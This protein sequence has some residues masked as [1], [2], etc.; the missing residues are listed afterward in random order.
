MKYFIPPILCVLF[1][2]CTFNSQDNQSKINHKLVQATIYQ[3][4]AA[5]KDALVYQAYNLAKRQ[6]DINI[7]NA[8][9][10]KPLAIISDI[11]E[12]LVDNSL[13]Y[14]DFISH[15]LD[16]PNEDWRKWQASGKAQA[17]KGSLDFMNYANER[18]LEIFYISNRPERLLSITV[19]NIRAKGF[20]LKDESHI[21]L[22]TDTHSKQARREIVMKDFN[23]IMLLGDNLG[24]FTDIFDGVS[25][26][27]RKALLDKIKSN[28]GTKYI[29]LPNVLYGR[30]LSSIG[31]SYNELTADEKYLVLL[32]KIQRPEK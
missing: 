24:D 11:D 17:L 6:L 4:S 22:R 19:D 20:P 31:K 12:T 8:D 27:K 32:D 15:N 25:I 10:S 28:I 23:V 9:K 5:E 29:I 2:G 3:Q 30:W 21:L 1:F 18:G 13:V 7:E 16:Y 14:G 26:E